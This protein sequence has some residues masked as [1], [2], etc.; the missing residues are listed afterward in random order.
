[1]TAHTATRQPSQA[2]K[3]TS[4]ANLRWL[5]IF[6]NAGQRRHARNTLER[7]ARQVPL[8]HSLTTRTQKEA[9]DVRAFI[10]R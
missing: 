1:M 9:D 5:L 2:G 8:L 10:G 3:G 6:G 7:R 4:T